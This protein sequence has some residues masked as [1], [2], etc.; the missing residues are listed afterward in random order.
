MHGGRVEATSAPGVGSAFAVRLPA[1]TNEFPAEPPIPVA[2][3]EV[4]GPS[5]R[6]LIVDDNRDAAESLEM[7][8]ESLGHE[9]RMAHTGPAGLDAAFE[10]SPHAVLLDIG[11]PELDGLEVAR[12]IRSNPGS[13]GVVLIAMTGYGQD[14][15]R[16]LSREAGFDH[17]LV[18][19]ADFDQVLAILATVK[20]R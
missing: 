13:A 16:R 8:L 17:H 6:V 11:L 2:T 4:S 14:D 3:A 18:K 10:Y 1:V 12:R 20:G 15:D 9:I 5:L 19:P 7:L